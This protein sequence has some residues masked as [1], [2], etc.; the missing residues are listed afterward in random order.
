MTKLNFVMTDM[1]YKSVK[2]LKKSDLV[3]TLD[4]YGNTCFT[5][6][7][8]IVKSIER[9]LYI[10]TERNYIEC[11]ENI[12]VCCENNSKEAKQLKVGDV[13]ISTNG[14]EYITNILSKGMEETYCIST[15]NGV[16]VNNILIN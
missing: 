15:E 5:K 6:I 13:I 1:G 3:E 4:R 14:Y 7:N 8:G 16:L 2:D 10:K 11:S 9:V 12:S